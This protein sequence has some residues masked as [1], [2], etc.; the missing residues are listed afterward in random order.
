MI[1]ILTIIGAR[2]QLIKASAISM[3][4]RDHFSKEISELILHTGQHYDDNMSSVFFRELEIP[5]PS[6][7]LEVGGKFGMQ[8]VDMLA[9]IESI[10]SKVSPHVVLVYGDTNSS[11]A[12]ALAAAKMNLHVVHVGRMYSGIGRSAGIA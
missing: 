9:G 8:T 7:N 5:E 12:G 4:I 3:A 2:P 11:L 6:Y 10:I 1:K